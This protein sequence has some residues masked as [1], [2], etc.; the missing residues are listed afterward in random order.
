VGLKTTGKLDR[1]RSFRGGVATSGARLILLST[2]RIQQIG[3]WLSPDSIPHYANLGEEDVVESVA[4]LA[5]ASKLS[6][7]Q[8]Q[9]EQL[10]RLAKADL[11]AMTD[12]KSNSRTTHKRNR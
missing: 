7:Q 11:A 6:L 2:E 4:L 3:D 5:E 9:R 8:I 10:G 12:P 1:R